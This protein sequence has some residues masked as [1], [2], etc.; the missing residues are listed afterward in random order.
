VF[1]PGI[2]NSNFIDYNIIFKN[3]YNSEVSGDIIYQILPGWME[4]RS[5]G[6]NHTTH[7]NYDTNVPLIWYGCNIKKGETALS[8]K[9]TQIAPTLSMLLNIPFPNASITTPIGDIVKNTSK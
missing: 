7:Y 2:N 3:S 4:K 6:T 5:F 9:I 1:I 8:V